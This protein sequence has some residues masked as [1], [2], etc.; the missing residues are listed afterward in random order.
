[1]IQLN[2]KTPFE[3][4]PRISETTRPIKQNVNVPRAETANQATK[5][6]RD[7]TKHL[8][9]T[10]IGHILDGPPSDLS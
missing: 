3:V 7:F 8:P 6:L 2:R 10:V 9:H 5:Y 1:M 4:K